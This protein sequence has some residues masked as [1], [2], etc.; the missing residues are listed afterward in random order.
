MSAAEDA[1]YEAL[2]RRVTRARLRR[3]LTQAELGTAVGL[4]R[5][6][7]ANIEAGRQRMQIHVLL[8]M[9][10]VL[11]CPAGVLLDAKAFAQA[12]PL[13]RPAAQAGEQP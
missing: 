1:L 6:S 9:A 7:I 4:V 2:G 3:G 8:A 11:G 13:A 10:A 12:F 5:S